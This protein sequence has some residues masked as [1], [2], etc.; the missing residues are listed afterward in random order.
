[1]IEGP[2]VSEGGGGGAMAGVMGQWHALKKSQSS[3]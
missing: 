3:E 1:M 2:G